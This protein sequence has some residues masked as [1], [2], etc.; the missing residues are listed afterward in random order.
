MRVHSNSKGMFFNWIEG[1]FRCFHNISQLI[2]D[3]VCI[4]SVCT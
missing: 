3:M 2:A 1:S 4:D